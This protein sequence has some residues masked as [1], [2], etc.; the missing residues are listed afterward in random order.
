MS[1]VPYN[2]EVA[3]VAQKI[4]HKFPNGHSDSFGAERVQSVEQIFDRTELNKSLPERSLSVSDAVI[5]A[6]SKLLLNNI[7]LRVF[8]LV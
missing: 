4:V 1:E 8:I 5:S 7:M 2:E 6:I 3:S